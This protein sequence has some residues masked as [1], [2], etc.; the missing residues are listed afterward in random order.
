MV[1]SDFGF[2]HPR[3]VVTYTKKT[4]PFIGT[5]FDEEIDF[6]RCDPAVA[7]AKDKGISVEE[8]AT[9]DIIYNLD[10]LGKIKSAEKELVEG[11]PLLS[12]EQV[13]GK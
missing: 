4:L 5:E 12:H 9:E 1:L 7:Y 11:R 6:T 10:I 3:D 2:A 8:A 13:F